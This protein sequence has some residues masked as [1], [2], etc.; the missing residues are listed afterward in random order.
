M[1]KLNQESCE[2]LPL[3]TGWYPWIDIRPCHNYGRDFLYPLKNQDRR[4]QV[5]L[6]LLMQTERKRGLRSTKGVV[7]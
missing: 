7:T 3:K 1:V 5:N 6:E 4:S 2:W